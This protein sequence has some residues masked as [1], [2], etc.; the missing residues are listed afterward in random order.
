MKTQVV[1]KN[2]GRLVISIEKGKVEEYPIQWEGPNYYHLG[3]TDSIHDP[4][5]KMVLKKDYEVVMNNK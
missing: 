5:A 3:K 2:T 1:Y 4:F